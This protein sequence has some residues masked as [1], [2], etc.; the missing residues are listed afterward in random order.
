VHERR[1]TPEK[2]EPERLGPPEGLGL[3][4]ANAR[5]VQGGVRQ[6][7]T[8]SSGVR[9]SPTSAALASV[10]LSFLPLG[11]ASWLRLPLEQPLDQGAQRLAAQPEL[12]RPR[13]GVLDERTRLDE[14]LPTRRRLDLAG[15]EGSLALPAGDEARSLEVRVSTAP[16][17]V[18]RIF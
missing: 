10:R 5:Q 12:F 6:A 11:T 18:K 7:S 15:D 14:R 3:H 8:A 1:E 4:E 13:E 16:S 17:L 9:P 2:A